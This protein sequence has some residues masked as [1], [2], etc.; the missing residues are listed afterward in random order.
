MVQGNNCDIRS[1]SSEKQNGKEK[2]NL[3]VIGLRDMKAEEEEGL[4]NSL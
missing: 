1:I 4:S 2:I 3:R